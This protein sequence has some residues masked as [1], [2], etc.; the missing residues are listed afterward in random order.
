MRISTIAPKHRGHERDSN[1]SALDIAETKKHSRLNRM[2]LIKSSR[3]RIPSNEGMR[4]PHL[5]G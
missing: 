1:F 4:K 3:R 5:R 2:K